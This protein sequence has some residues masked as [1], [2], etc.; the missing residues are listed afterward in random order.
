MKQFFGKRRATRTSLGESSTQ[1]FGRLGALVFQLNNSDK[2]Y[3]ASL[4]AAT[5]IAGC[6]LS[7]RPTITRW[8]NVSSESLLCVDGQVQEQLK[9][10]LEI[11]RLRR[12]I[13]MS[14]SLCA[15]IAEALKNKPEPSSCEFDSGQCFPAM[16]GLTWALG[17]H[18]SAEPYPPSARLKL[19]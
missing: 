9:G 18:S 5:R 12:E 14:F 1:P 2:L 6:A 11:W 19:Q 15:V 17:L 13:G 8:K 10:H 16:H 4:R 3:W 7:H